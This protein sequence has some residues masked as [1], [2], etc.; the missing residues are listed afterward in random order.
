MTVVTADP[1]LQAVLAK[2]RDQAEV[3]DTAGNL[4]GYFT[5]R[6]VEEELLYQRA[7]EVF[8]PEEVERQLQE[9][10]TG[11]TLEQV[12]NHFHSPG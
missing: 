7:E 2:L 8:K 3:R 5:P 4:L 10:Q 12:M 6:H 1:S 11:S 9:Q